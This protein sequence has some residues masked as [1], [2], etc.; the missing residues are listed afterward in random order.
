M[1]NAGHN[2]TATIR[3]EEDEG[4]ITGD[5]EKIAEL[6]AADM[7]IFSL[8]TNSGD[9]S[10]GDAD[11]Q[12]WNDITT[13]IIMMSPWI[14]RTRSGRQAWVDSDSADKEGIAP[15]STMNATV[16]GH[17]IFAGVLDGND[18]YIHNTHLG[19][20]MRALNMT[21]N[22]GQ[23]LAT[24]MGYFKPCVRKWIVG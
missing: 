8:N 11:P 15:S 12:A 16:P 17:P 7:I 14:M 1:R 18:Q 4:G 3:Y 13:P 2:V 20:R 9:Y 10:N 5:A 6:E 23:T 22:S 21:N 19:D 24:P